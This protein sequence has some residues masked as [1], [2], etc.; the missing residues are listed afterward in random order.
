MLKIP[1]AYA[2]LLVTARGMVAKDSHAC[3][4]PIL[5]LATGSRERTPDTSNDLC[6]R[7]AGIAAATE[8]RVR[9]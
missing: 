6:S 8:I 5:T 2:E 9:T 1:K 7:G 4:R 3:P